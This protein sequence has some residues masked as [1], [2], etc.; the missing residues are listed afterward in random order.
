MRLLQIHEYLDLLAPDCAHATEPSP[1]VADAC[2]AAA[3]RIWSRTGLEE[4]CAV[5]R[6]VR[7]T[8]ATGKHLMAHIDGDH[9]NCFV[10]VA[11]DLRTNAPESYIVFDIGSEYEDP[12]LVCPLADHEG[13]A[14]EALIES[15]VPRLAS[16]DEPYIV[17]DRGYGTYLYAS[18]APDGA[19]TL[20]HQLVTSKNRYVARG[21]ITAEAVIEAFKSYA[22]KVKEWTTA[23]TWI[24]VEVP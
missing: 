18:Q 3:R 8:A 15:C 2:L 21:P 9:S 6:G 16:H 14:T 24:R 17:L 5:D 22:F 7:Y 11:Y 12:V 13:P 1:P 20:E 10:I 4:W 23:F 19:Y